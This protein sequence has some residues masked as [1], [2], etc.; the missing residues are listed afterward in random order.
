MFI[1][2]VVENSGICKFSRIYFIEF[3]NFKKSTEITLLART[4]AISFNIYLIRFYVLQIFTLHF[5]IN[6]CLSQ[7]KKEQY[8]FFLTHCHVAR[9]IL[10]PGQ[11][12]SKLMD[13]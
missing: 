5:I 13:N 3:E 7:L 8:S 10:S 9:V 1:L 6:F 12:Y 2:T 11:M 4:L